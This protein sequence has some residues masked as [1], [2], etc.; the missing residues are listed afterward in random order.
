MKYQCRCDEQFYTEAQS[1]CSTHTAHFH[2]RATRPIGPTPANT[3]KHTSMSKHMHTHKEKKIKKIPS[4]RTA[5][6]T[7]SAH[8][9]LCLDPITVVELR[10]NINTHAHTHINTHTSRRGYTERAV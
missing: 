8:G 4:Q 10:I 9:F 7:H 1:L 3:E 5:D 2:P 6:Q